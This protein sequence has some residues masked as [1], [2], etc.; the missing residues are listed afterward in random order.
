MVILADTIEVT[1]SEKLLGMIKLAIWFHQEGATK[2]KLK[3]I[4]FTEA[5]TPTKMV[6]KITPTAILMASFVPTYAANQAM[7]EANEPTRKVMS[8]PKAEETAGTI[9]S[10][11]AGILLTPYGRG[12]GW[13][14]NSE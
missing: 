8:E 3:R 5:S 10:S 11:Q 9:A 4:L 1:Q 6:K 7:I 12:F 2:L 13:G 14:R